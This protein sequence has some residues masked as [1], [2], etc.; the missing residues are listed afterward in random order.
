MADY[1]SSNIF[2]RILRGEIPCDK[3]HEDDHVLA[4][5]DIRPQAATHILVI[6]KGDYVS[7]DDF[8][9][10]AS[11]DEL[12]AFLRAVGLVARQA[13]VAEDGY[14]VIANIGENGRQEVQHLH[15]HVLGGT[16][17]GPM[18]SRRHD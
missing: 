14:R 4:F 10:R 9:A 13:G 3:V 5:R 17:V 8:T 15:M 6:P 12:A 7:M 11:D 1:D 18:L 16:D 2:A